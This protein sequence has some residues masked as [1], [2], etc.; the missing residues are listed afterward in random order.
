L[1]VLSV[2]VAVVAAGGAAAKGEGPTSIA[3]GDGVLWVG[4]GNG[5]VLA[6]DGARDRV[7]R[8]VTGGP[9]SYVHSLA[10][11]FGALWI[12]RGELSRF[13]PRRDTLREVPGTAGAT[14]IAASAGAVWLADDSS[15]GVLRID[16]LRA[17]VTARVPVPGRT[18]GIAAGADS[19]IVVSAPTSGPIT[20]PQGAR[21]LR[22]IDPRTNRLSPPLARLDCDVGVA[23]G[24]RFVLTFDMCTGVLARR[25]PV[26]LRVQRQ[27]RTGLLSQTPALGFGS[28]WLASRGGTFRLDPRT[29][30]IVARIDARSVVVTVGPGA[31]WAFDPGYGR[32]PATI[33]QIDPATNRLVDTTTI[34]VQRRQ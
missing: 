6:V 16:P 12:V 28:V 17:T 32:R 20:G 1:C 21:Q 3:A 19:V 23:A 24:S 26:T 30:Q 31:V 4:M 13:D 10:D 11:R 7:A 5:D 29:L 27:T 22:R 25:N 33:R 14:V 15:V 8:R 34:A 2:A 18:L 9:T